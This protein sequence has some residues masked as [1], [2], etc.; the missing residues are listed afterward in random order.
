LHRYTKID[1]EIALQDCN[2]QPKYPTKGKLLTNVCIVERQRV[3]EN[4]NHISS[5]AKLDL[6][7]RQSQYKNI[8]YYF[9]W[10][11]QMIKSMAMSIGSNKEKMIGQQS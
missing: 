7:S 3:V 8:V 10:K 4:L 11:T 6:Y 5:E 9:E 2:H 1:R